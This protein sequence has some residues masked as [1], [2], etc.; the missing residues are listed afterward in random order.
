MATRASALQLLGRQRERDALD[1]VLEAAREGHG[2]VLA[3]YGEAG[4]GKT[5]VL[6][7]AVEA[8]ADF[9][10]TRAL[11]A[12]GEME[13]AFAALHQLCAPSL[14][15]VE[16]LPDP[17]RDALEV[18]LG[19]TAGRPPN[20]FL[21]GL[22]VLNLLS[23]AAELQPVLC[24]VDDAQ[25]LDSA[26]ARVLAFVARRLLA[27]RVAMLF[28]ARD[29][30]EALGGFAELQV[31]PLGHRDAR[32]LLDSV[33]PA[34][35]DERVLEQIVAETRG[36]PLALLE[37]PR[38]LTPAQLAGGFGL[39][40]ALPLSARIEQS[41]ERRLARLPRD[42]RR[43]LLVAAADPTGDP[44][45]VWRAGEL[46]GIKE[47]AA[48][49]VETEGLLVLGPQVAFR[50]PLVRSAVYAA[51]EPNERRE[52]HRALAEATDPTLEPDRRAWHR[53][54]AAAG[55]DEDVAAEL[56]RSAAR[57]Q[58]RGGL[59][60]GAAFLERAAALTP[61]PT[62]RA[63]RLL[64]AAA[65]KRDAG[66]LEAAL[67][68]LDRIEAGLLDNLA[69][70]RIDLLRAQI[71]LEQRRSDDAG[72][73][74]L[75]AASRLE[76]LDPELARETY[77]DALGGAMA[78]DVQLVGG[79]SAVAAAALA[80]PPGTVP[81][82]TVDVLLD[83]FAIRLTDGFAAAA[84]TL[85]QAL[86]RLLALDGSSEGTGRWLSLSGL[87]DGNVIAEEMWDDEAMHLLAARHVQAA[88]DAGAL[89]HLQLALSFLARNS[90]LAGEL[91][92]SG[93]LL[94]EARAI[95][96]AT[97]NQ[98]LVNA[99]MILAAWRGHESQASE[100]IDAS[101]E[102]A[103]RR[104]WVSNDYARCVL[105]NGLGR[106]EEAR[107]AAWKAM[108]PDPIGYGT[109]LV[110]ELAEAAARTG[111]R[112]RLEF[113]VEWLSERTGVISSG[114]LSGIDTRVRALLSEDE[115]AD[116]LYRESVAHLSG[117]RVRLE[118]ARTH[119]LYGEWLRRERR[120]IDAREHL[121]EALEA[122]TGMGAEAFAR[123]AE[124]ELAA[125]GEHARKRTVETRSDL[126]PQEAQISRLVTEGRSNREIA[127]QLF[128]SPSTV[129]YHLRKVF[130]KLDVRSRTQLANRLRTSA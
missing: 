90:M 35:L 49:V 27:E 33:L 115:A 56:E 75:G 52:I 95:A 10:V 72:R 76:R 82:R 93:Q 57:A 98:P 109:V 45:L 80:G 25:W 32:A 18:A 34:R 97:G 118:L 113:A 19:L 60:A 3:V 106:H 64:A 124:R 46:L 62:P 102:E 44:A 41:F 121:R 78:S 40:G 53:A 79:P 130:R 5:A 68:L 126:T 104:G 11:G 38:G 13:L 71:A 83:A 84:P 119:L 81:P 59:A 31:E 122:F 125:T 107:D 4:V 58:A 7:Y 39:P 85:A 8:G 116:A 86:E 128:I 42:A 87:R 66:E 112:A 30:L 123:R 16:H 15:L 111:D 67:G 120:R 99:P 29:P 114:W 65:A 43:L 23:E 1:R 88:R 96:E 105:Y 101:F 2:G 50:H 100:L 21:V 129:E 69:E 92:G 47:S 54:Q 36:N 127:A 110:P 20:P 63:R 12:E 91:S 108:K 28:A 117:T 61:E 48:D 26:S 94:D 103:A 17:Q 70:V 24:L 22:A 77:L 51:V 9:K 89:G 55:P 6:G 14:D 74:F 73:L 37:L